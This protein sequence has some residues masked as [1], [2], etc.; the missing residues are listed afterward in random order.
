MV[1]RPKRAV[2]VNHEVAVHLPMPPAAATRAGAAFLRA[3]GHP[4]LERGLVGVACLLCAPCL[5]LGFYLDD[6]VGRYIYSSVD[7]G[8]TRLFWL[9][10]GGYG[11]ANGVQSD[12]AWQIEQG[13]APWWTYRELL[14]ELLRP[15]GVVTHFIDM[16]LWPDSAVLQHAHNLLWLGL[17]VLALT[18]LYRR[19]LGTVVGGLA[20][21]LF[22]LDHTHGFV[23]GYICNRH[24]LITASLCVFALDQHLRQRALQPAHIPWRAVA[25]YALALASGE[26][27]L[28]ILG[29]LLAH[30]LFVERGAWQR[31]ALALAPYLVLTLL[32]RMAY[33]AAGFGARGSGLYIDPGREPWHFL[34][35]L[36]ERGPLLLLGLFLGPP[37][38]VSL[39]LPPQARLVL[40]GFALLVVLGLAVTLWPLLARDRWARCWAFGMLFALVPAAST[41][42]H[43][44]QL[45]F[46]SFGALGL[47]ALLW[48]LHAGELSGTWLPRVGRFSKA[49]GGLL[50]GM[51]LCVSPLLVPLST[52]SPAAAAPI[53]RAAATVGDEIEGRDVV[54]IT[55][56]DYFAVKLV[57]LTRRID[58]RPLAR[59]WR[60]LS[61]GAE[62]VHV[63]RTDERT[64]ILDYPSGILNSPFLE[65]YRDR[66]LPMA[67]GER[68][69]LDGLR[70]E[71]LETTVDG[72]AT[73]ARFSFDTP[74]DAPSFRFYYWVD[75]GFAAFIPPAVGQ[76]VIVPGAELEFELFGLRVR[77]AGGAARATGADGSSSPAPD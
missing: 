47:I 76:S 24:T 37:A 16:Q 49:F 38:E 4:R 34:G 32:W 2:A 56:P 17:L 69:E 61:F 67:A 51:R 64:I 70:I 1:D 44:R 72:R 41:Y 55:A 29:Y 33:S 31:R 45:T 57:Q 27:A 52:W 65:L 54:F 71:V 42:P 66:R 21:L 26:S 50:L 11:L 46:A 74:L 10:S 25:C 3:L 5:W 12:T 28:A 58:Q 40:L 39:L 62:P 22:A 48:Q 13:F 36:L 59:R 75:G 20:A 63:Q 23:V 60:A 53:S 30:L 43:N 15:F 73:R 6:Y 8:A 35:A 19:A 14:L 68:I 7:A 9:L 77:A 18:R